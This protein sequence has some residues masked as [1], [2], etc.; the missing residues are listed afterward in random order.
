MWTA[1]I[2]LDCLLLYTYPVSNVGRIRFFLPKLRDTC[3]G[4]NLGVSPEATAA[5]SS[6]EGFGSGLADHICSLE[7][8]HASKVAVGVIRQSNPG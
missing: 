7:S 6:K 8:D 1:N 5:V 3:H 4:L 2:D